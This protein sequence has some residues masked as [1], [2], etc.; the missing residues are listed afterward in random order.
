MSAIFSHMSAIYFF[1]FLEIPICPTQIPIFLP[2]SDIRENMADIWENTVD[3]WE[4]MA[5]LW[6]FDNRLFLSITI[7]YG[8]IIDNFR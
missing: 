3:I 7:I 8:V 5:N 6:A 1:I 4:K 2:L